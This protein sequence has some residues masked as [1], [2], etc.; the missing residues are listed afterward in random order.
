MRGHLSLRT[1]V[2]TLV[3]I[4]AALVAV[5]VYESGGLDGIERGTVD[6]RFVI[7]GPRTPGTSIVIVALDSKSLSDLDER[8]P[9][10]RGLYAS[11]LDKLRAAGPRTIALDVQFQGT[12]DPQDDR[13]LVAAVA[14]DGPVVLATHESTTGP[15]PVP[16]GQSNAK[17][18][19]LA[20]AGID[21]DPDNVL[22]RMLYA[23]IKLPTLAVRDAE[24]LTGKP[25]GEGNFPDNHAWIDFRGPPGTFPTYSFVDVLNGKVPTSAFAGK[26][27]LVGVTD[28]IGK[29][30]YV[31]AASSDPMSG[32]EIQANALWTILHGFPLKP[33]PDPINLLL[34]I[35]LAGLPAL[36]SIRLPLLYSVLAVLG[37]AT[38]FLI[39]AQVLFNYGWIVAC[40]APLLALLLGT[41]G[42]TA[43]DSFVERAQRK[44]LERALGEL[45]P[46]LAPAAFFI[47]YR[48][49]QSKWPARQIKT[50]LVR[51][52]GETSVFMDTASIPA[53]E[54]WPRRIET[55][56]RG[57]SVMLVLI[58]PNW[59]EV[60]DGTRRI[61]DPRDWVRLEIEA[62]LRRQETVVV[63]VLL[64]GAQCPDAAVLPDSIRGL[65]TM[66][67]VALTGDRLED[68]VNELVDSIEK[69]RVRQRSAP[70]LRIIR[71][72]GTD[73]ASSVR[74]DSEM[75]VGS[76]L[77]AD[78]TID[79]ELV[80]ERHARVW[81]VLS[82]MM[83]EDLNSESG[84]WV[85]N[86]R[87]SSPVR[88]DHDSTVRMGDTTLAVELQTSISATTAELLH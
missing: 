51:K 23:P 44:S 42:A 54:E 85:N 14:R 52:F 67:A 31:T 20:D 65:A 73:T 7:R 87:I 79:D 4:I 2:L 82:G 80:S 16:A 30:I 72:S 66:Q 12:T 10:D 86:E 49:D 55:A 37:I 61:D 19:I 62:G 59:L 41:I 53:G 33:V 22:R 46:P 69:G 83:I 48:R 81:P 9:I 28:P 64:D 58:G 38:L 18:A 11:L 24:L 57:C 77:S 36:L 47:S 50:E 5:L 45:L 32:V 75:I 84:T 70:T 60:K 40:V 1:T 27:V 68:E 39:G 21:V 25:V 76:A 43:G 17:G 88:V 78:L 34:V 29:D 63:P 35:L 15:L 26:A 56:I 71:N 6:Q 13:A 8:Y 74:V 3:A